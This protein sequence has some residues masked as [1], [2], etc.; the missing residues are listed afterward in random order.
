M[1]VGHNKRY[2]AKNTMVDFMW[3]ALKVSESS[4]G[5]TALKKTIAIIQHIRKL[6]KDASS[7]SRL[8]EK[9]VKLIE[10]IETSMK[11]GYKELQKNAY[12]KDCRTAMSLLYKFAPLVLKKKKI[13]D[14]LSSVYQYIGTLLAKSGSKADLPP[15]QGFDKLLDQFGCVK[16]SHPTRKQKAA[17]RKKTSAPA[18]PPASTQS[19]VQTSL[20]P[21]P[22]KSSN[23]G[24][25]ASPPQA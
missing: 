16:G 1:N 12:T 10:G 21:S 22:T 9:S 5:S 25:Q 4:S 20:P 2:Q 7:P 13:V 23:K 3:D 6:E 14:R 24:L 18:L 19:T 11:T 17:A 15:I 8:S